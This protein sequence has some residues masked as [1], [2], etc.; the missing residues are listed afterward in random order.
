M[1]DRAGRITTIAGRR[2]VGH[3]Q[4]ND[5][6]ERDPLRLS[7]PQISS[8]D[9]YDDRLFVPTDLTADSGDLAVL[10]RVNASRAL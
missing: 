9:W 8:M 7:L 6:G 2:D 1:V 5:R 4:A 10:R 3:E